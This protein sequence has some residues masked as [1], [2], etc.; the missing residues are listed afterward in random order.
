MSAATFESWERY[1]AF[2]RVQ[3]LFHRHIDAL[4]GDK[5][6]QGLLPDPSDHRRLPLVQ[7]DLANLG[8]EAPVEAD[9][10]IFAPEGT[11]DTSIALGWLYGRTRLSSCAVRYGEALQIELIPKPDRS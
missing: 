8:L 3:Y 11:L 4:Y 9:A 5:R 7:A 1:A 6:L 2:L 10:S